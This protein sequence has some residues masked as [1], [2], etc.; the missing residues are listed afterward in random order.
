MNTLG[1][2]LKFFQRSHGRQVDVHS[3][4]A[5]GFGEVLDALEGPDECSPVFSDQVIP[6]PQRRA[7]S[8]KACNV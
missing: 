7:I 2:A 1:Q 3:V 6:W 5:K 4:H 8:V